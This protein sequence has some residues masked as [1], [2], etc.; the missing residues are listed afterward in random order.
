MKGKV[1]ITGFVIGIIAVFAF[2]PKQSCSAS[3]GVCTESRVSSVLRAETITTEVGAGRALLLD[4]REPDEYAAG[5]A[6]QAALL[7]LGDVE[8]GK[9]R[10]DDRA[11]KIYLY[12]RS[13]RRAEMAKA[14]LERQGYTRVENLGG[15]SDWQ[16]LG[17]QIAQ[18]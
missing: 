6:R 2:W 7:P 16:K 1:L 15:L 4:V 8:A 3:N 18:P 13:G 12:C 11:K 5:H 14:A 10:E 17:G 9:L